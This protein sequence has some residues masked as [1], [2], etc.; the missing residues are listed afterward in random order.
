MK[1]AKPPKDK[2]EKPSKPDKPPKPDKPQ[3]PEKPGEGNGMAN[4][5]KAVTSDTVVTPSMRRIIGTLGADGTLVVGENMQEY[6]SISI[7]LTGT[8]NSSVQTVQ[9]SNDGTNY[10]ALPTAVAFSNT[11][12]Y[13][14]VALADLGFYSMRF[15][16][17][18]AGGSSDLAFQINCVKRHK[19][20]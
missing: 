18:S 9:V 14:T 5:V 10:F 19:R 15:S 16:G 20:H 2:P 8:P 3:K 11:T 13:K 17:A 12:G 4:T 1:P 7:S 6:D